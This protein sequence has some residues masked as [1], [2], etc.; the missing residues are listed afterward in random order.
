MFRYFIFTSVLFY[1]SYGSN[2]IYDSDFV[3]DIKSPH[4]IAITP[5]GKIWVGTHTLN[6]TIQMPS[7][8]DAPFAPIL[9]FNSDGTLFKK[10]ITL[11][12]D[13][14]TDTLFKRCRGL[15]LDQDGNVLYVAFDEL[16]KIDY[17]SYSAIN[18][19]I[20]I[21]D[22]S[23]TEAACDSIGNIYIAPVLSDIHG[24]YIY[25]EDFDSIGYI[26]DTD[27]FISRSLLV[28]PDG[29]YLYRG[30]IYSQ[31]PILESNGD[32]GIIRYYCKNSVN[33][34]YEIVDT[35]VKSIWGE[36]LDWD[37]NGILWVGSYWNAGDYDLKGWYALDPSQNFEIV[38]SLGQNYGYLDGSVPIPPGGTYYAP[39]GA[40]WSFNSDTMYTV[41]FDGHVI[42]KWFR[43]STND[44]TLKYLKNPLEYFLNQNYPNPFNPTTTIRYDI[45]KASQVTLTIYNMN[46]Q[47]VERLVNKKQEPGFYSVNWDARNLSTGVYFY[48]I[49]AGDFQQVKKMILL[50]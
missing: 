44:M 8:S 39:R 3:Y 12:I 10:L 40:A 19:L 33:G 27:T 36:C 30:R 31:W 34:E 16:W 21:K 18:K 25:N 1:T 49:Q 23:L 37:G 22:K 26:A 45:P 28:S 7:G 43:S 29:S 2:W 24:I 46:G 11:S 42:K 32:N 47:V 17:Q 6:D 13:S 14:K 41:D 5:N 20:V 50:K 48:Q 38:D 35:L 15:S 9:I 4:G